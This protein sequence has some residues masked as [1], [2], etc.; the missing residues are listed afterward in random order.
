M[1]MRMIE[2]F[3]SRTVNETISSGKDHQWMINFQWRDQAITIWTHGSILATHWVGPPDL[4]HLM[5]LYSMRRLKKK[6][7]GLTHSIQRISYKIFLQGKKKSESIQ[8]FRVNDLSTSNREVRRHHKGVDKSRMWDILRSPWT[9]FLQQ[10][11]G[12]KTMKR[13]KEI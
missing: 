9:Q 1:N 13:L 8:A 7:A 11:D 10:V 5:S 2:N 4:W 3:H 12:M 6:S